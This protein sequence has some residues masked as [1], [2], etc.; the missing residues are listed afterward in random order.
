[1]KPKGSPKPKSVVK[2]SDKVKSPPVKVDSLVDAK[3][4]GKRGTGKRKKK[5][6]EENAFKF[7][8]QPKVC[9]LLLSFS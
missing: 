6:T 7:D 1:M 5:D 8:N 2:T 4:S 3:S 9:A